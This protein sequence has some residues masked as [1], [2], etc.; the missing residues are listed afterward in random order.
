MATRVRQPTMIMFFTP[1]EAA[2]RGSSTG[3]LLLPARRAKIS[4]APEARGGSTAKKGVS[5]SGSSHAMMTVASSATPKVVPMWV[6]EK[7]AFSQAKCSPQ[8]I[9]STASAAPI[10][11]AMAYQV[12]AGAWSKGSVARVTVPR[13]ST[14]GAATNSER[15]CDKCRL[16]PRATAM[17]KANRAVASRFVSHEKV[18]R[19]SISWTEAK[20][21]GTNQ[22][23]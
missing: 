15:Q 16:R 6:T 2:L 9:H 1:P 19:S 8:R 20:V 5:G 14:T 22:N 4:K 10:T 12:N 18:T 17:A 13:A 7:F 23:T 11:T 21:E 3:K